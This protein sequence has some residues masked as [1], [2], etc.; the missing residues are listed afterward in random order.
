MD[1]LMQAEKSFHYG[2]YCVAF[3]DI[4]GQRRKLRA[5]PRL[6][7]DDEETR[8]L[9]KETAG[10]V[11]RLRKELNDCFELFGKSTPL[12][13][14]LPQEA[15]ERI[16]KARQAVKYRGFSDSIIMEISIAGDQEQLAPMI[17][18]YGCM[19]ACCILHGIALMSKRPIRGGIDV[20]PGLDITENE[21]YGPVLEH[22]HRLESEL[23]D[24]PRIL[25]GEGL[26]NYLN[27]VESHLPTTPMGRVAQSL[28]SRSKQLITYDA[29]G[30]PMLDF[31]GESMAR[32]PKLEDWPKLFGLI[33]EYIAEQKQ[34]ANS[35]GDQ[36]HLTRYDRLG[37]YVE[38]RSTLWKNG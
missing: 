19:G 29:D 15:R 6:P 28:A 36:K 35:Q 5:L 34:I 7:K 13:D 3:L 11:L 30:L 21:V 38:K 10:Y 31:L 32:S 4:L 12:L 2:F 9:L 37:A 33:S 1:S 18:V 14:G 20:G 16:L 27:I 22:A 8:N 23:A 24:Y 17:G 26:S 25:V